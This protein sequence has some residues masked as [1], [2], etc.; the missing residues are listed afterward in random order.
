ME[1]TCVDRRTVPSL[2]TSHTPPPHPHLRRPR[3]GLSFATVFVFWDIKPV[4]YAVWAPFDAIMGYT[5]PR[6]PSGDRMHGAAMGRRSP[7]D[8]RPPVA[9][10]PGV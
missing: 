1:S 9:A 8:P 6:K 4:F 10:K 3:I 7:P 2:D 5:D